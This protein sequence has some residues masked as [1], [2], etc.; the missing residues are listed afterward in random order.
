MARGA[1]ASSAARRPSGNGARGEARRG[2]GRHGSGAPSLGIRS[3][4]RGPR[5]HSAPARSARTARMDRTPRKHSPSAQALQDLAP[6]HI[7]HP[8][9]ATP[10]FRAQESNGAQSLG[11]HHELAPPRA[12]GAGPP[13]QIR[14]ICHSTAL[15]SQ[16]HQHRDGADCRNAARCSR[17]G[18]RGRQ[19]HMRR[20]P[21]AV[22]KYPGVLLGDQQPLPRGCWHDIGASQT[23]RRCPCALCA[24]R[25]VELGKRGHVASRHE[26]LRATPYIAAAMTMR[27]RMR[28]GGK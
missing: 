5:D 25:R 15:C 4:R 12:L 14:A 16:A 13:P 21:P 6:C 1:F 20:T 3:P 9:I 24:P 17:P 2:K 10:K 28:D 18:V 23:F 11:S 26:F 19:E 7:R 8:T 27:R 22:P